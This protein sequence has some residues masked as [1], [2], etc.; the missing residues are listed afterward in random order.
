MQKWLKKYTGYQRHIFA[1]IL[2]EK[3]LEVVDDFY[4]ACKVK[5]TRRMLMSTL[6][7]LNKKYDKK[8]V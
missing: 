5:R 6:T 7:K 3:E 2:S 1:E 8:T 4:N